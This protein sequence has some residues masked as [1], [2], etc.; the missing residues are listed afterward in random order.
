MRNVSNRF[1]FSVVMINNF[2]HLLLHKSIL[3]IWTKDFCL[4]S[5]FTYNGLPVDCLICTM[6]PTSSNLELPI[7]TTGISGSDCSVDTG[8][9]RDV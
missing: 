3:D 9:S 4:S 5:I 7:V 8:K 2:S 1:Y 6:N